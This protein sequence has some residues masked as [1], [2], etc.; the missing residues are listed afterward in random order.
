MASSEKV[1][2]EPTLAIIC[3][4]MRGP[5]EGWVLRHS[6]PEGC[7]RAPQYVEIREDVT[8]HPDSEADLQALGYEYQWQPKQWRVG[9]DSGYV[10]AFSPD[11]DEEDRS[12]EE[13]SA[14]TRSNGGQ[15][16]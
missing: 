10:P 7:V 8:H 13:P 15:H 14:P 3:G 11:L 4:L 16:P 2:R 9:H 12:A 1:R 5:E 6:R